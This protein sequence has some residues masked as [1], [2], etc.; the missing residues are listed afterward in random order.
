MAIPNIPVA[1][2]KRAVPSLADLRQRTD[3]ATQKFGEVP[4][5]IIDPRE[6]VQ[7]MVGQMPQ[8]P[9][10]EN[11]PRGI[12][13]LRE[14]P[15]I[16]SAQ[17][18]A[19]VFGTPFAAGVREEP[20]LDAQGNMQIDPMTGQPVMRR[21]TNQDY[22]SQLQIEQARLA[23]AGDRLTSF[24]DNPFLN[25]KET[26]I[27]VLRD[28]AGTQFDANE[29]VL[30]KQVKDS[31]I[32]LLA[33]RSAT[34]FAILAEKANQALFTNDSKVG[35]RYV[36]A[37]GNV[38]FLPP[39]YKVLAEENPDL[40]DQAP[41]VGSVF[42]LALAK[43][44]NQ[45]RGHKGEPE[46]VKPMVLTS[47]G[48]ILEGASYTN[49]FINSMTHFAAQGL[50]TA[51]LPLS[52]GAVESLS[53]AVFLDAYQ[54]GQIIA[55]NDPKTGRPIVG[56]NPQLKDMSRTVDTF[57]EAIVGDIGR[58]RS[59]T[60]PARG[61]TSPTEGQSRVTARSVKPD[62]FTIITK[63]A[64]A[65]KEWLGSVGLVFRPDTVK[66]IALQLEDV[67]N[68]SNAVKV[69]GKFAYSRSIYAKRL[70]LAYQDYKA[71]MLKTKPPAGYNNKDP[72][73]VK[74]FERQSTMQATD[75]MNSKL[76]T[77]MFA[78]QNVQK[79]PGIR[80][81][82][83]MHSFA[84]QRFFPA[85]FD[86]DYM[87][88]KTIRDML[89]LAVQDVVRGIDMFDPTE[90]ARIKSIGNGIFATT[91]RERHTR[92]EAL[93]IQNKGA[94]GSMI[95]AVIAYYSAI[96]PTKPNIEKYSERDL[97]S[98]YTPEIG[99]AVAATG[100]AYKAWLNDPASADESTLQLITGVERGEAM[101][102]YALWTDFANLKEAFDDPQRKSASVPMAHH[103]F[104]D[105]NQNGI[106]LQSLFFGSGA[107]AARLGSYN[108]SMD[109]LRTFGFGIMMANLD[110]ITADKPELKAAWGNFWK[111]VTDKFGKDS[112]AKDFFKKPLMQHAYGKDAGMFGE[113]LAEI[114]E[115]GE[116]YLK[117]VQNILVDSGAYPSAYDAS[118]DLSKAVEGSLRQI[119]NN[120][121]VQMMKSIGRFTAVLN[122]P[123]LLEGITGD[124]YVLTPVATKLVNK[125]VDVQAT[126]VKLPNGKTVFVKTKELETTQF[127]DA[128]G[129]LV[130]IPSA[131]M[132]IDPNATKGT[133][134][135]F[136]KKTGQYDPFDNPIGSAQARSAPVLSIQSLDGDLVKWT[137]LFVNQGRKTPRAA[138]WVHDSIISTPGD[139]LIYR[140][141][142]N[143]VAIREAIPYIAQMGS[144][145]GKLVK[146]AKQDEIDR[147]M[148]RGSPVS[149][150]SDGEYPSL[151]AYFQEQYDR[152]D[153]EQF[154]VLVLQ[155]NGNNL[156]KYEKYMAK[157]E[158]IINEAMQSGW[159]P[160]DQL[161]PNVEPHFAV[162]P[163]QFKELVEL[164]EEGLGITEKLDS[165][166]TNFK[167]NVEEAARQLLRAARSTGGIAQM[168][169]G[170]TG[171]RGKTTREEIPTT[172]NPLQTSQPANTST[173][174]PDNIP[175]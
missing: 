1:T 156:A 152:I 139:A 32:E 45:S 148:S 141:A 101:G 138:L 168:T 38:S 13:M 140:N 126:E 30:A 114:L 9:V 93:S 105:G 158:T 67:L 70:G 98:M 60:T 21:V 151:G 40:L 7:A 167:P 15:T 78:I 153:S 116:D 75:V 95:N 103:T 143:N 43:A 71:A 84:N 173:F 145:F 106:F 131:R 113:L 65:A 102:S 72:A 62:R 136:N 19:A 163:N 99:N 37:D 155:R 80:Y 58:R 172:I 20:I 164:A 23:E 121:N 4:L 16:E 86:T 41:V 39:G 2:G 26:I 63:A 87:G 149:I 137:T 174:D 85:S 83:W 112:V 11:I 115:G 134:Y 111:T 132:Q 55:F 97:L 77:V 8:V 162:T 110:E 6:S 35:S 54:N 48:G 90:V 165:W 171:K 117:D 66:A 159:L 42:G 28:K 100:K 53:K 18:T 107:N 124:T 52:R 44:A 64:E 29:R 50:K 170:A 82:E 142:Y 74:A 5:P 133:Q 61:G 129:N 10:P 47:D 76:A 128:Q 135:F 89:G 56:A 68:N 94:I 127:L 81:S 14:N 31:D 24:A 144:K 119:I 34:E 166:V 147:V 57:A 51:G 123:L 22:Q 161:P 157:L 17:D 154:K 108:P 130:D 160:A 175:F 33:D 69:E 91:G 109:D 146:Q 73:Q 79:S 49:D 88:N 12:D 118:V 3:A 120:A 104:D 150:G 25:A 122:T 59:M 46:V 169:Q 36:D 96:N 125:N 27:G 92:L